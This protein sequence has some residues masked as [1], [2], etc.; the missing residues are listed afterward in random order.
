MLY[1]F[2]PRVC[3]PEVQRRGC[4]FS[5]SGTSGSSSYVYLR[6]TVS[7]KG[8]S[9]VRMLKR[10][11]LEVA[12]RKPEKTVYPN[13]SSLIW[14]SLRFTVRYVF[15][16]LKS[17]GGLLLTAFF[18]PRKFCRSRFQHTFSIFPS[19]E[20]IFL[21]YWQHFYA[22]VLPSGRESTQCPS[23][24]KAYPAHEQKFSY[25]G[26]DISAYPALPT[27]TSDRDLSNPL[28]ISSFQIFLSIKTHVF[29][30][31]FRILNF[32]PNHHFAI[33]N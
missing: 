33:S 29:L 27:D 5:S 30:T 23:T 24:S 7:Q 28:E 26:F 4:W 15:S 25:I 20:S 13:L 22:L 1:W 17:L 18:F 10:N 12:Q 3:N 16:R 6:V 32:P 9:K 8:I 31:N 21:P 2:Q 11:C 14:A 19:D